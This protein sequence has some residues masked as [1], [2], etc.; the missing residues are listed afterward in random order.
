MQGYTGPDRL[1]KMRTKTMNG[2][3]EIAAVFAKNLWPQVPED[4]CKNI[5][6]INNK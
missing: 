6:N 5:F 4:A 2:N 1:M 3:M